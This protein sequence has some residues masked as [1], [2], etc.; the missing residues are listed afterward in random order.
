MSDSTAEIQK[1]MF[2]YAELQDQSDLEAVARL[3]AHGAFVVDKVATPYRGFE[4]VFAMK[5]EI[6]ILYT[7]GSLRTKHVTTNVMIEADDEQGTANA[8]SYFTVFQATDG[9]PL[10]VIIAGRYHD[11]FHRASTVRGGSTSA[12]SSPISSGD[13]SHHVVGNLMGLPGP[14]FRRRNRPGPAPR[15]RAAT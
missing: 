3:F 5:R 8:R 1:L 11:T 13:M 10:Q 9:F 14:P 4:E 2:R 15:H 7:D 6:E 12:S